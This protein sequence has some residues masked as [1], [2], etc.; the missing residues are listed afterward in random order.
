MRQ[1]PTPARVRQAKAAAAAR[2]GVVLEM[3]E[4][5]GPDEKARGTLTV[6]GR[7]EP[8]TIDDWDE[9]PRYLDSLA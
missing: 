1:E 4:D 2:P 3:R 8:V 5:F 9:W 7:S 6:N